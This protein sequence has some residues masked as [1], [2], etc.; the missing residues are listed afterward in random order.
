MAAL[1]DETKHCGATS[2][3]DHTKRCTQLKGYRTE[4]PS[5]GRC[6]LH[7]GASPQAQTSGKRQLADKRAAET[8][9]SMGL[10]VEKD[11]QT[12]LLEV[13]W[14]A[15]GNVA[16][17][18]AEVGQMGVLTQMLTATRPN[19]ET[20]EL[21]EEVRAMVKLYGDWVDRLA[22]YSKAAID[23][24]IAE[25][26]VKLAEAQGYAIRDLIEAVLAG[27]DV[28]DEQRQVGRTL[29]AARLTVLAGGLAA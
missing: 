25:R 23:A 28:S 2:K 20:V 9:A 11:P 26:Q 13:V 8:L 18:R 29:A 7:G 16:F 27:M 4:H 17:L 3:R 24:G 19:G 10:P 5:V 12:A 14:E 1:F 6:W 21:G 22:K 15:A